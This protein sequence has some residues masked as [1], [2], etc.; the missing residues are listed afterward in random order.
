MDIKVK[1]TCRV[2]L[3]ID[4]RRRAPPPSEV[5]E[6][7]SSSVICWSLPDLR[8]PCEAV[9]ESSAPGSLTGAVAARRA[10]GGAS[11]SSSYRRPGRGPW[12]FFPDA[13]RRAGGGASLPSEVVE[14]VLPPL[15]LA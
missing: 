7:T 13:G 6:C 5:V 8:E 9:P 15:L 2:P 12:G 4:D 10:G 1:I 14:G 11:D 3:R